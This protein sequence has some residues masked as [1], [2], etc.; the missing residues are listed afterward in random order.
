M[1]ATLQERLNYLVNYSSQLIFVSGNSLADQTQALEATLF[2]QHEDTELA[3]LVA[4]DTFELS[5]YRRLLCNQLIGRSPSLSRPLNE[6]LASLNQ[7]E[8][9][10]MIAI[11]RAEKM[12]NDV[13][14][15]L[16]ELVLQ[17]RFA[18][19]KQHLNVI[20]FGETQ[21]AAKAKRWLPANNTGTPLLLSTQQT[22]FTPQNKTTSD[23]A[24]DALRY[25]GEQNSGIEQRPIISMGAFWA[26]AA[27]LFLSLSVVIAVWLYGE[28]TSRLFS[29]ITQDPP[30]TITQPVEPTLEPTVIDWPAPKAVSEAML[31][32]EESLPPIEL[33]KV[34][35]SDTTDALTIEPEKQNEQHLEA[36]K[37]ANTGFYIQIAGLKDASLL[38]RFL[39]DNG[40]SD[41]T[42]TYQ[43]VRYGGPWHVVIMKTHY[44]TVNEAKD[45]I[46][47][48]DNNKIRNQAFVKSGEAIRKELSAP[49]AQ[50]K[51]TE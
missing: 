17:S 10:V 21:W 15:E 11:T 25:E 44:K 37:I 13:L 16:W 31:S 5:D 51:L 23:E 20:L 41:D 35:A 50:D 4:D 29:P 2:Q 7:H 30:Q 14:Q 24:N 27:L 45:G 1:T 26:A 33:S 42:I 9:P 8:G 22:S 47:Q 38:T 36:P 43:T 19:N 40:L 6:C 48:L 49:P 28:Q 34:E 3:Y 12:P 18:G 39:R 32:E 46:Q